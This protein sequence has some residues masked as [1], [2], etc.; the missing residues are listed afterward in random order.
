MQNCLSEIVIS[1]YQLRYI[2][3]VFMVSNLYLVKTLNADSTL[4]G[5]R[6]KRGA[7]C[8]LTCTRYR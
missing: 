2:H 1:R 6:L 4:N 3:L 7:I 8:F 5:F